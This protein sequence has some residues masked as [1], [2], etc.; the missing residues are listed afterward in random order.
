MA[1]PPEE[2]RIAS[3]YRKL[4]HD[5]KKSHAPCGL[6]AYSKFSSTGHHRKDTSTRPAAMAFRVVWP[7]KFGE[8]RSGLVDELA[9]ARLVADA[10]ASYRP[11]VYVIDAETGGKVYS[12][13]HQPE[14]MLH[15]VA[16][17]L[18]TQNSF[19]SKLIH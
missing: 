10:L 3:I 13:R 17:N 19:F 8:E 5:P 7:G 18:W 6:R 9:V 12:T 2:F 4:R 14:T 1:A 15:S 11:I 16:R